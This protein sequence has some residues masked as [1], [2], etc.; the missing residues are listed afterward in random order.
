MKTFF[1]I[2]LMIVA[3]LSACNNNNNNSNSSKQ[4]KASEPAATSSPSSDTAT[5]QA[6]LFDKAVAAYLHLKNAL[7]EDNSKEAAEA[8]KHLHEAL[9]TLDKAPFEAD[10]R[11]V[12]DDVQGG[13]KE[14]AQF[15]GAN[16]GKIEQ[17]REHFDRLSSDMYDLVKSVKPTQTLYKNHCPM[18]NENKGAIWISE[19]KEIRNPY[20]GKKMHTCG[21]QQEVIK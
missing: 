4:T 11:K 9:L 19:V 16:A 14:H 12:Y 15:I 10:Q 21:E 3:T 13:I 1:S 18:F 8:G 7:T 6:P 17:Q 5:Q 20:Y 2:A